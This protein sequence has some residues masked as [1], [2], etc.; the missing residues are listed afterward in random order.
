MSLPEA[1]S[2]HPTGV[3]STRL[4]LSA[5][6]H[7]VHALAD[8][9]SLFPEAR[10][11][12]VELGTGKGRFL[13]ES[14]R[15]HPERNFLGFERSL[16]YYRIARDRVAR[17]GLSN[18]RILRA[19]AR[20]IATLI[21]ESGGDA[22]HAYFLDP[23]PKKKQHKRRLLDRA[24]LSLLASRTRPNGILRIVTDHE[25]YAAA[26]GEA[27]KALAGETGGWTEEE[28]S[29]REAPPPTHYE[30]KYFA[31]GRRIFRF[32]LRRS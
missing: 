1:G 17:S 2:D 24:F 22:F 32:L 28:W 9:R 15:R 5:D 4:P 3:A 11:I 23:W 16:A 13:I 6:E 14:G 20:D 25:E 27:L 29:S 21:P 12:E 26:I 31:A 30:L 8:P 18:V 7:F 19:D 10:P